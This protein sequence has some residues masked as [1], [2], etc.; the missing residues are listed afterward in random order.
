MLDRPNC[1]DGGCLALLQHLS[2]FN[3]WLVSADTPVLQAAA[4]TAE[5]ASGCVTHTSATTGRTGR[6]RRKSPQ[7]GSRRL[8]AVVP[9]E[10]PL[11]LC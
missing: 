4:A 6:Y 1:S 9:P 8:V 2:R 11:N 7:W 10:Q 3:A 5:D